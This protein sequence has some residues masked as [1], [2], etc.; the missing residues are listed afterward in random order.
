MRAQVL[1][2]AWTILISFDAGSLHRT[3]IFLAA[4]N[5]SQQIARYWIQAA[6]NWIVL[7]RI[8]FALS[9]L[10]HYCFKQV[11]SAQLLRPCLV[12]LS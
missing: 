7:V 10:E 8:L 4:C 1:F 12:S 3:I 11:K 6:V 9:L 2:V 5:T